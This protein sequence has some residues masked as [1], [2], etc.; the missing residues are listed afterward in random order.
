MQISSVI[1]HRP[2]S[3]IVLRAWGVDNA[4][5]GLGEVDG[6]LS[7]LGD[8]SARRVTSR[9]HHGYAQVGV[10]L[11]RTGPSSARCMGFD[12]HYRDGSAH[13]TLWL[14]YATKLSVPHRAN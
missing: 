7:R 4:T 1:L 11:V 3:G 2:S 9:C 10:R 13:R 6:P 5:G 14:G 12:V 8:Y